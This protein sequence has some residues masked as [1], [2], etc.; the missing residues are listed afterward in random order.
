MAIAGTN[1]RRDTVRVLY[2]LINTNKPSG[3]TV[4]AN[5][6]NVDASF[7]LILITP[8][9][10]EEENWDCQRSKNDTEISVMFTIMVSLDDGNAK[11]DEGR[12]NISETLKDTDNSGSLYAD[13]NL[14]LQMIRDLGEPAS[15]DVN[16]TVYLIA[17]MMASFRRR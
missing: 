7:P 3:W 1:I 15:E 5:F 2:N 8:P 13:S 4:R 11:I 6:S 16:G 10:M 12:D 9:I 17:R 14:D